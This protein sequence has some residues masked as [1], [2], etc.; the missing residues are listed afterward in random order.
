[1]Y[2]GV[3]GSEVPQL[4][5]LNTPQNHLLH[6]TSLPHLPALH[7]LHLLT[8]LQ[9][10]LLAML[11]LQ[12]HLSAM[13]QSQLL[14]SCLPHLLAILPSLH[15][16]LIGPEVSEQ[17]ITMMTMMILRFLKKNCDPSLMR[18]LQASCLNWLKKLTKILLENPDLREDWDIFY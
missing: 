13:L 18:C 17:L 1:M 2:C 16:K 15:S 10:H 9:P 3:D 4:L 6:N 11:L 7:L 5:S 8:L 12:L 14:S